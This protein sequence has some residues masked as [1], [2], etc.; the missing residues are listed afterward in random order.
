ME[1]EHINILKGIKNNRYDFS[2]VNKVELVDICLKDIGNQDSELRDGL[3]YGVLAHLF[4]D[5]QLSEE[6][7]T[8][9]LDKLMSDGFLFHDIENVQKFSV[10]TRSFSILQLAVLVYVHQRDTIIPKSS[11]ENLHRAFLKYFIQETILTG[12]D[13]EVGWIHAIA[14][15]ADLFAQFMQVS[16]FD[17]N[18][19][20]SMFEVIAEKIKQKDHFFMFN[21][22]ERLAV[23]IKHGIERKI[24]SKSY[25]ESWIN[26][27]IIE[28]S[29]KEYPQKMYFYNNIKVFLQTL[30]STFIGDES[31]IWLTNLIQEILLKN[32]SQR[33]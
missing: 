6:K 8:Y 29:P 23:A 3:I 24:L 4:Y 9:Y 15:S 19:L 31:L 16:W 26:K 28:D 32:K 27:F 11:I 7:L 20:I 2:K 25:I 14:H 10:L 5:H 13:L 33:H 12:Y 17:E 22:D 18:Q 1:I 30:Y 21:E